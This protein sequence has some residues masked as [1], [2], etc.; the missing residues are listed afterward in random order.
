MWIQNINKTTNVAEISRRNKGI[1]SNMVKRRDNRA[2][3]KL[4][5]MTTNNENSQEKQKG[6]VNK[7]SPTYTRRKQQ[8][9]WENM[10]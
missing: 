1:Y 2:C 7:Y 5:P 9:I 8:E 6:M 4:T 3:Q 10:G